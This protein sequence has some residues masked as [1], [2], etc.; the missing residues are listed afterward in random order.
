MKI[1][2]FS[3]AFHPNIGGIENISKMLA[4][5]F[6]NRQD[7]SVILV[8]RIKELGTHQFPFQVIRD[9]SIWTLV[10]LFKWC[11]VVFENNPCFGMSWPNFLIRKPKVIAL[12]TW[13]VQPKKNI[14]LLQWFK[15]KALNDYNSV[16]ACSN[17]IR[18]LTF[19]NAH[20]INNAYDSKLY[21]QST[22]IKTKDFVFLGRLVSDKGADMC[23]DLISHLN[24]N[25]QERFTLTI[26]GDGPEMEKLKNKV[27]ELNLNKQVSF[28]GF[29]PPTSI[30]FELRQHYFLL[31][32][33]RWEEPFG[34][35]VLEG[36]GCGCIPIVSDG[37]GLPDAVGN[38]GVIFKRNSIIDL[39][40]KT[41]ELLNN[42]N[43]QKQLRENMEGHLV[44]HT[45]EN[46]AQRYFD[47]VVNVFNK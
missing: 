36:M 20:V 9:P 2:F 38:A 19:N 27:I 29:L 17:K 21:I 5:N 33:S 45:I 32:P 42:K 25:H 8:T 46:I 4:L 30:Q 15:K 22:D 1:L 34:I 10:G 24:L 37:G 13:I 6:H 14:T 47:S 12:H 31:V 3:H 28:L 26:I 11:D 18:S 44:S 16:I 41:T 35:V 43:L 7:I 40:T 39:V 23:I